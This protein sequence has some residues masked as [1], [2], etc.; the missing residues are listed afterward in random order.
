MRRE[1]PMRRTL[2]D[3]RFCVDI[4]YPPASSLC[5]I[6]ERSEESRIFPSLD[7]SGRGR[8][9]GAGEGHLCGAGGAKDTGLKEGSAVLG[10]QTLLPPRFLGR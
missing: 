5:V 2:R 10:Q 1:C 3:S 9:S 4:L 6:L 8:A 7:P